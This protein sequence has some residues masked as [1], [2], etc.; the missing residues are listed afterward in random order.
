M[1]LPRVNTLDVQLYKRHFG[2]AQASATYRTYRG[3]MRRSTGAESFAAQAYTARRRS[4][5][6]SH[7]GNAR[8]A[9]IIVVLDTNVVA[10][11]T[12]WRGKPVTASKRGFLAD[13]IW[14]SVIPF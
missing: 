11:A 5:W 12:F 8:A 1:P 2:F 7:S 4:R 10:S 9:P 6:A 13:M 14:P 3:A